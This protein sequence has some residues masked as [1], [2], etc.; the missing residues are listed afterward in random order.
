MTPRKLE[1]ICQGEEF[2]ETLVGI[3]YCNLSFGGEGVDCP[4]QLDDPD[5]NN[6][7]RC[8]YK[9]ELQAYS[10]YDGELN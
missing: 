10:A 3:D 7:F 8:N 5:H 1:E 4:Y 6:L 9:I 2:Q